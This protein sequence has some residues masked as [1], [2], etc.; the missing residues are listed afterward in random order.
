MLVFCK[1]I[2]ATL[3][4]AYLFI[5][6]RLHISCVH[7]YLLPFAFAFACTRKSTAVLPFNPAFACTRKSTAVLP[8]NPCFCLMLLLV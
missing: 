4:T 6:D 8:F 3:G 7:G 1:P 5:S 2:G